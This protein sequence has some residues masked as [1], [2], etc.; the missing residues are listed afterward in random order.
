MVLALTHFVFN[1]EKK[2]LPYAHAAIVR[3]HAKQAQLE[4]SVYVAT[5]ERIFR[6]CGY[7]RAVL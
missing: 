6:T 2:N 3:K 7:K 1:G 4:C 5:S